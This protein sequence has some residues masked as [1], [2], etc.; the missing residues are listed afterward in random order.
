MSDRLVETSISILRSL[1][2]SRMGTNQL[3]SQTSSD[4]S[5]VENVIKTMARAKLIKRTKSPK[6]HKQL[7]MNQLDDL[8]REFSNIQVYSHKFQN[9]FEKFCRCYIDNFLPNR[10][11][12]ATTQNNQAPF[13][14]I[15]KQKGWT[16]AEIISYGNTRAEI[17][18]I[19]QLGVRSV[20][21]VLIYTY[22]LKSSHNIGAL[23]KAILDEI[24]LKSIS[25]QLLIMRRF[26]REPDI[27]GLIVPFI[28]SLCAD[29]LGLNLSQ[30][31][32]IGKETRDLMGSLLN[33]VVVPTGEKSLSDYIIR[34]YPREYRE[35]EPRKDITRIYDTIMEDLRR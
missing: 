2:T 11:E 13:S 25:D 32:I 24:V 31:R 21:N 16:D 28:D 6:E 22:Q 1:S 4:K 15:L 20:C 10:K 14:D 7:I 30:N 17:E 23:P 19:I 35:I 5:Y 27:L 29:R 8:G 12:I 26:I 9:A 34:Y 33:L 3:I 18:E